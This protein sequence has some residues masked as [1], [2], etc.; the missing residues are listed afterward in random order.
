VVGREFAPVVF[1]RVLI[2]SAHPTYSYADPTAVADRLF[3][4]LIDGLLA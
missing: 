4:F 2:A 3:A 1:V